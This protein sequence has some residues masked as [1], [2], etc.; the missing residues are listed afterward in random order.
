MEVFADGR[1]ALKAYVYAVPE[2][3]SANTAL[4]KLISKTLK[5]PKSA[6]SLETEATA[7]GRL[8]A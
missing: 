4:V 8:F 6:I 1:A 2:K 3:G 5:L 7:R